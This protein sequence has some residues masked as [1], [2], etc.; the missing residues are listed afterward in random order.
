MIMK[1]KWNALFGLFALMLATGAYASDAD[2][3]YGPAQSSV[4]RTS[5]PLDDTTVFKCPTAGG[6]TLPELA[7][8]G[9]IV[10][11]VTA[12]AVPSSATTGK[13]GTASALMADRL[14]LRK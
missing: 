10:V 4:T 12:V 3:C 14:I 13:P 11:Q 1:K 2:V 6:H 5:T 7:K 8:A 9:W